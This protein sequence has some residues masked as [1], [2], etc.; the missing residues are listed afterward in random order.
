[1]LEVLKPTNRRAILRRGV[2]AVAGVLGFAVIEK[3]GE[4]AP[5]PPTPTPASPPVGGLRLYARRQCEHACFAPGATNAGQSLRVVAG[6]ELFAEP[7]GAAVGQL[8]RST[9]RT[10]NAFGIAANAGS[11]LEFETLRLENGVLFGMASGASD[12]QAPKMYAVVGGTGKFA[13]ARGA[14][15]VVERPELDEVGL[16]EL[17]LTVNT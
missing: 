4:A 16:V 3:R 13:G 17:Q 7:G 15:V 8:S 5:A 9:F 10:A 14:Y 12:P 2:A 6:G 1:M 11:D